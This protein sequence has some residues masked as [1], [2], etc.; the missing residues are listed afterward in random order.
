MH[1]PEDFSE[2]RRIIRGAFKAQQRLIYGAQAFMGFSEKIG[3]K[4]VHNHPQGLWYGVIMGQRL[5]IKRKARSRFRR[6]LS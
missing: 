1:L 5:R 2:G 3:K 6:A 4:I